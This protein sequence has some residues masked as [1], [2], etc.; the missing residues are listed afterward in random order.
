MMESAMATPIE[1]GTMTVMAHVHVV[2]RLGQ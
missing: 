2:F 1:G